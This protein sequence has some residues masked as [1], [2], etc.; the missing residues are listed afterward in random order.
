MKIRRGFVTNSSSSSFIISEKTEGSVEDVYQL[1]RG[2]YLEFEEKFQLAIE[3]AKHSINV[4]YSEDKGLYIPGE[5]KYTYEYRRTIRAAFEQAVHVDPLDFYGYK[6]L[7]EWVNL[8]NTYD[9]YEAYWKEKAKDSYRGAPFTIG[10]F[11]NPAITWLWGECDAEDID[12]GYGNDILNWFFDCADEFPG[13]TKDFSEC[14]MREY[15]KRN[16]WSGFDMDEN[17]C[18]K[19]QSAYGKK[20]VCYEIL[21]RFCIYSECG[22]IPQWI[23]DQLS[24]ISEYSCNHMG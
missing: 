8:C 23:V 1:I 20:N 3:Y 6:G 22:Y 10:D 15:Y 16:G 14:P 17:M 12:T 18:K 11:L 9:E 4:A 19:I 21:G 24:D 5:S 7:P 2:L 13:C